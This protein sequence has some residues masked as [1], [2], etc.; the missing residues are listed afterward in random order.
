MQGSESYLGFLNFML[1][2]NKNEQK[3][4]CN[5]NIRNFMFNFID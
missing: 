4:K 2:T 3:D 1:L 5:I